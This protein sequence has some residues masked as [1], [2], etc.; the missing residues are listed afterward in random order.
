MRRG[1]R[2]WRGPCPR[3]LFPS[4]RV[5]SPTLRPVLQCNVLARPNVENDEL[6]VFGRMEQ[7]NSIP[8]LDKMFRNMRRL[9]LSWAKPQQNLQP[10]TDDE[11]DAE[12]QGE[13][14]EQDERWR[15]YKDSTRPGRHFTAIRKAVEDELL[16]GEDDAIANTRYCPTLLSHLCSM[17]MPLAP[18]WV[19]RNRSNASNAC[20]ESWFR[21]LKTCLLPH[22]RKLAPCALIEV[23][24]DHLTA[25]REEAII[26]SGKP[27]KR[28]R[29][30]DHAAKESWRRN[31]ARRGFSYRTRVACRRTFLVSLI[32][33]PFSILYCVTFCIVL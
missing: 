21:T 2:R 6:W 31:R 4:A 1:R 20:V 30:A 12:E 7:S 15:S 27:S 24:L 26:P 16:D 17:V 9:L 8:E 14:S 25:K 22:R 32:Y 13:E 28:K 33:I 3:W 10:Y 5:T 19:A 23:L 18:M 29:A 11:A